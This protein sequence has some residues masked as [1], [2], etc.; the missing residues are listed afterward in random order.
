MNNIRLVIARLGDKIPKKH[1]DIG[2]KD[3]YEI[4]KK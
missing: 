1:R 3:F 2:R 4:G